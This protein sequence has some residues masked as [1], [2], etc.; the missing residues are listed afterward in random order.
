MSDPLKKYITSFFTIKGF[1]SL[2]LMECINDLY[3]SGLNNDKLNILYYLTK[4]Q[5]AKKT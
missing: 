4:L 1:D 2:W 3:E 5:V